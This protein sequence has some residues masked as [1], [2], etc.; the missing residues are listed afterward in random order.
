VQ[1]ECP[2]LPFNSTGGRVKMRAFVIVERTVR[3]EP[4]EFYGILR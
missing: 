3:C 2:M 1:P 4:D